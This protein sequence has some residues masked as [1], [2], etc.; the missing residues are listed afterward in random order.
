[1]E[2]G[3]SIPDEIDNIV[4]ERLSH[5]QQTFLPVLSVSASDGQNTGFSD[6]AVFSHECLQFR[7]SQRIKKHILLQVGWDLRIRNYQFRKDGM[8]PAAF[9]AFNPKNAK[10]NGPLP[11]L[12][13]SS[14]ITVTY[15]TTSMTAAA[16]EPI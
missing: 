8:S 3:K 4:L 12:K 11:G 6:I 14:V 13:P 10:D 2:E 9:L 1:M 7:T 16:V 5:C 15:Q